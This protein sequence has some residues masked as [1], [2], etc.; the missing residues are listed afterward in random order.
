MAVCDRMS[1]WQNQFSSAESG[2]NKHPTRHTRPPSFPQPV[3]A[4]GEWV[5]VQLSSLCHLYSS[6]DF[7]AQS[8]RKDNDAL[9]RP[10]FL[11]L[12]SANKAAWAALLAGNV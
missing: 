11:V 9:L 7:P 12:Q 8:G 5:S 1:E 3:Y 10:L 4:T 2:D 6:F